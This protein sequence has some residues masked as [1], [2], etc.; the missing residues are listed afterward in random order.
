VGLTARLLVALAF[1]KDSAGART[2]RSAD[3]LPATDGAS[4]RR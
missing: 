4:P 2:T 3:L 1:A